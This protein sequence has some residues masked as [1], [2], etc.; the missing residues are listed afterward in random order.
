[1]STAATKSPAS[2][3]ALFAALGAELKPIGNLEREM[4]YLAAQAQYRLV[5]STARLHD[6][7]EKDAPIEDYLRAQ[8][9]EAHD[10]SSFMSALNQFHR[11]ET[12]RIRLLARNTKKLSEQLDR[13]ITPPKEPH[14][15]GKAGEREQPATTAA[16]AP[17]RT[18][19]LAQSLAE[20]ISRF[21]ANGSAPLESS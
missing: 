11:L 1:M 3:D 9:A 18:Q 13:A 20:A 6:L 12:R 10:R 5:R 19:S 7:L 14:A 16:A 17:G 4:L 21:A 8:R 15:S 2:V